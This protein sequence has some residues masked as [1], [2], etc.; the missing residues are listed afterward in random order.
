ML[1]LLL[2]GQGCREALCGREAEPQGR[3]GGAEVVE[4]R[5][6]EAAVR[7]ERVQEHQDLLR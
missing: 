1:L 7:E 6:L 5:P 4:Q 3:R 2:R